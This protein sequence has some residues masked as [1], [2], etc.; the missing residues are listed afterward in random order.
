MRV[1]RDRRYNAGTGAAGRKGD[2]SAPARRDAIDVSRR[3]G[4]KMSAQS[5]DLDMRL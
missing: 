2:D 5:T 1:A 4:P 3:A